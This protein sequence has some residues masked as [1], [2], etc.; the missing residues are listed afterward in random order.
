MHKS[1]QNFVCALLLLFF[2]VLNA[3]TD[4]SALLDEYFNLLKT[5]PD[6]QAASQIEND[7]WQ[8]WFQTNDAEVDSLMK[9]ALQRRQAYDFNGAIEHLNTIIALKPEYAE[10][11]NQRATVYFHQEKYELAL[12]DVAKTLELEPRHFGALA[13]RAIIRLQQNKPALARQ[14]ILQALQIHPFLK[15]RNFFPGVGDK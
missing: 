8:L 9:Q 14:N 6:Q 10:A 7:I 13:G 11:W 15:E 3:D 1:V 4:E 5:A 12:W 2:N